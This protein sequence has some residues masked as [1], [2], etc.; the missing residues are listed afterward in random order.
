MPQVLADAET[1]EQVIADAIAGVFLSVPLVAQYCKVYARERFPESDEEDIATSTVPDLGNA[2]LRL[3]SII[4]VGMP[5]VEERP[6]TDENCTQLNLTYPITFD[7]GV[8]NNWANQ[9]NSLTYTNS[10]DLF[11]A[12][13]LKSRRAFKEGQGKQLGNFANAIHEYL[14]MD[15]VGTVQ[16]EETGGQFHAAEWTLVV[17]ITGLTL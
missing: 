2:D 5:T 8:K 12:I 7:M 9:D 3:T 4:Q 16:D 1:L 6:Y 17:K 14:Q 13:Y 11:M 15:F 10:R